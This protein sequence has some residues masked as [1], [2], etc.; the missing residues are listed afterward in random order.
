M[1]QRNVKQV[2]YIIIPETISKYVDFKCNNGHLILHF[3]PLPSKKNYKVWAGGW[4]YTI[5]GRK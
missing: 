4:S 2:L 1:I 5:Y 3:F